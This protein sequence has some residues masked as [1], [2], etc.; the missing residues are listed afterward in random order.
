M[1]KIL[2]LFIINYSLFIVLTGCGYKPSS[3]YAKVVMKGTVSTEIV[4]SMQDPESTVLIKDI[5]NRA[6]IVRFQSS[7]RSRDQAETHLKISLDDVIFIPMKYDVNGYIVNYRARTMLTIWRTTDQKS[8][9]YKASG[10]YDFNI[11]PSAIISDFA[12][13]EAI[14]VGSQKALDSF[15]A[16]VAAEGMRETKK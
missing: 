3:H 16:Q 4:I 13:L 1:Y 14:K 2:T 9:T 8:K 5:I 6:V 10:T 15:V 11:E 7:L 12:R